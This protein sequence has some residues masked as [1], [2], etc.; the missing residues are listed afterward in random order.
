MPRKLKLRTRTRVRTRVG[1]KAKISDEISSHEF[2]MY[3]A[4][5]AYLFKENG[6][7]H[8][9]EHCKEVVEK[10]KWC[11]DHGANVNRLYDALEEIQ[12]EVLLAIADALA[13]KFTSEV[14]IST[15]E[16]PEDPRLGPTAE[17]LVE[18]SNCLQNIII[19]QTDGLKTVTSGITTVDP[20]NDDYNTKMKEL[21]VRLAV[22][23]IS[24]AQVLDKYCE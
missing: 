3:D 18:I 23:L 5:R 21:K 20:Q 9:N 13:R 15:V 10:V 22:L 1:T 24:I 14:D 16:S 8:G 19:M 7:E 12:N 6:L 11:I 4:M 17:K 2:I